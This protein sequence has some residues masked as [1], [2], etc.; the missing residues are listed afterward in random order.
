MA[1][2]V[3]IVVPNY[4][5]APFLGRRLDTL[6]AQTCQDFELILLDDRSTDDTGRIMDEIAALDAE[7]AKMLGNIRALL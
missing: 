2:L 3:S 7:S 5:H 6:L 1:P 4:N